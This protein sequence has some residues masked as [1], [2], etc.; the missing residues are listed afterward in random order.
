MSLKIGRDGEGSLA[1]LALVRLLTGVRP[2]MPGQVG[3][4]GKESETLDQ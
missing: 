2:K 4:P 3:T 1:V